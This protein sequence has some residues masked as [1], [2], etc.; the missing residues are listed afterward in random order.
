MFAQQFYICKASHMDNIFSNG[1]ELTID[2][3][4]MLGNMPSIFYRLVST[5]ANMYCCKI[6]WLFYEPKKLSFHGVG[7]FCPLLRV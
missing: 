2:T 5:K 7:I 4:M 6:E 3:V 1:K